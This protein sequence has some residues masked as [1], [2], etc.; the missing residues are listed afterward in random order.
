MGDAF[1]L[2]SG[3]SVRFDD[4]FLAAPEDHEVKMRCRNCGRPLVAHIIQNGFEGDF[5]TTYN[6]GPI[7]GLCTMCGLEAMHP[8][9]V[10]SQAQQDV[11]IVH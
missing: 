4:F 2:S 7:Y 10:P 3:S 6:H 8:R 5:N 9:N 11:E 1:Y